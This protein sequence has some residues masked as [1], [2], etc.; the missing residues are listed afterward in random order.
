MVVPAHSLLMADPL[1]LLRIVFVLE[2]DR[3]QNRND[4]RVSGKCQPNVMPV[5]ARFGCEKMIDQVAARQAAENSAHTIGH[6][7]EQALGRGADR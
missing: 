7:H 1:N 4:E 2:Q 6:H 5:L 3:K